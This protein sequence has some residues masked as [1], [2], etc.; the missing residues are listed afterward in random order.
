MS[1]STIQAQETPPVTNFTPQSYKAH[2]QN[3]ALGQADDRQMY[4]A[5]SDGLLQYDGAFWRTH[6]FPDGQIVRTLLC[7]S[8]SSVYQN[9]LLAQSIPEARIYVGGFGEFGYWKKQDNGRLQYHSLSRK[10]G[11]PSLKTE[12]I[13]HI[14]RTPDFIYFQSFS[15]IYRYDGANVKEIRADGTIMYARYVNGKMV[16]PGIGKGLFELVDSSFIPLAGTSALSHMGVSAI[17]PFD[18]RTLLI[19]TNKN[20]LFLYRNGQ[21]SPWSIPANPTFQQ[22]LINKALVLP[23]GEGFVIGTIQKGVYILTPNGE[24]RF[25]IHKALGLQNNTVLAMT[26]DRSGDLWLGLD[27]GIDLVRLS[28]P[29]LT[30]VAKG[31]P[32]GTA[33]TAA[34]WEGD[35]YVGTNNGVF[36]KKW[37]SNDSFRSVKGLEGQTWKLTV[38]N[39]ELLCGHNDATY[40]IKKSGIIKLSNVTG[41][42]NFLP[43]QNGAESLLLQSSYIGLHVYRFDPK[44][45]WQYA[46]P[47]KGVPPIP[48]KYM[49]KNQ[50]GGLWLSHAYKGLYF[51]ELNTSMD[52]AQTWKEIVS[53][54]GLHTLFNLDLQ[55]LQDS[56]YIKA[57]KQ[58]FMPTPNQKLVNSHRFTLGEEHF[59]IRAGRGMDWFKVYQNRVLLYQPS[60]QPLL[61]DISLVRDYETIIPIEDEKYL[62]CLNDGFA[63]YEEQRTGTSPPTASKT[64]I[65]RLTDLENLDK[66]Y[67]LLPG[68]EL[69]KAIR[70]LRVVF[71]LPVY[72]RDIQYQYR[73]KG[74]TN[75]WSEWTSQNAVDY[76]NLSAGKYSF[77][78]RDNVTEQISQLDFEIAAFWYETFLA[79]TLFAGLGALFIFGL[80]LFQE[81]RLARH[82]QKLLRKQQEELERQRKE[83]EREIIELKNENLQKEI[84]NKS[85]KLSNIAINVVRKNEILEE[86]R[87]ELQ[88]VKKELGQQLPTL[89]YQKLLNSIERNVAGKEDWNL[90]EE[91]FNEVHDEFFQRL[92]ALYPSISPSELRLAACLRM[93]LSTK[94][95]APALGISI[96]GVEIKRY[97]LRKKLNLDPEINLAEYMMD[98]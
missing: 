64:H 9:P 37:P 57:G 32:L 67:P 91:N 47:I 96:R 95:M 36:A 84:K 5:N 76:T 40:K 86:I 16:V 3:W 58:Y 54:D 28:S 31:N 92:R 30:Y 6:P 63:L 35:L 53:T 66:D 48:I 75:R 52:S 11:L 18:E 10:L 82:R 45:G 56:I 89:H 15:R 22:E 90:F 20:G 62:F 72:G 21:L 34:L 87:D 50:H 29:L 33:Y 98:I 65:T 55:R 51:A 93:N 78:V 26:L 97:R 17:L 71:S 60:Q 27:Q 49:A 77:E 23:H 14:E 74:L 44:M 4:T 70:S 13:W 38:V 68:Y 41:G 88:Q 42:W 8:T 73:L 7:E 94:E 24:V 85:Q 61:F 59:K 81:K 1:I 2:N 39:G 25:H 79:K 80:L 12:E 43:I 69:P 19:C 83:N 46:F